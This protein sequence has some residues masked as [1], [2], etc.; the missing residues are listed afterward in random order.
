MYQ[1]FVTQQHPIFCCPHYSGCFIQ[2]TS[3][4]QAYFCSWSVAGQDDAVTVRKKHFNITFLSSNPTRTL[5]LLATSICR[6][7]IYSGERPGFIMCDDLLENIQIVYVALMSSWLI[8]MH[9]IHCSY[10]WQNVLADTS[11]LQIL[12]VD[13][14]AI[15]NQYSN[16]LCSH[17]YHLTISAVPQPPTPIAHCPQSTAA[18]CALVML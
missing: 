5:W 17:V 6:I 16:F 1:G 13:G 3:H 14:V 10:F 4:K 8:P 18:D 7:F 15:S 9:L 2:I 11:H 12:T